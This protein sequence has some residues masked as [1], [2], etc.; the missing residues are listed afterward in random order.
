MVPMFQRLQTQGMFPIAVLVIVKHVDTRETERAVRPRSL[1]LAMFFPSTH[2]GKAQQ[3]R[4]SY[5]AIRRQLYHCVEQFDLR[6]GNILSNRKG[7][8]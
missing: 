5:Q 8:V 2:C 1:A 4:C 7:K 3:D 6:G